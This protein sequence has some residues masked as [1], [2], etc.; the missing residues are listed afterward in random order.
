MR[1][2]DVALLTLACL[3]F[4]ACA[5]GGD[6]SADTLDPTFGD[7]GFDDEADEST[8]DPTQE[9]GT[10][11]GTEDT[12]DTEDTT[13]DAGGECGNGVVE[14]GEQCDG[15]DLGGATCESE[16]F[17]GGGLLCTADCTLDTSNC[18]LCGNGVVDEDEE[19]DGEDLGESSTC[20]DLNLG[21]AD[22]PLGCTADCTYD[23]GQCSGCGDG[24]VTPPEECE[25]PGD[26]LEKAELNGETCMSLG[27]DDG[28][29][30]CTEGCTFNTD[31]CYICGDA[32][33]QGQEECDGADFG[34]LSCGD[35][36][37]MSGDP[38][39]SG[40][41]SCGA[42]CSVDTSNCSL[43]GDGVITGAE[44]CDPGDLGGETCQSQGLDGGL[45]GCN[46][47]CSGFDLSACTDC[48]DG[49]IEG[50][51]QCDFN[52]LGGESCV[53]QGFPGGGDL[54]CTLEC[55]LDTSQCADNFCGDGIVNGSDEC[56]CGNQGVNCT[57][58]Q[59]GNQSCVGLGFDGGALACNSPNNC[60]YDT[61]GC[62]ECGDGNVD[63][64]EQCDGGN[65]DGES[66]T[67]QGFGGGGSL[68]CNSSC[69]FDT[70]GCVDVQNPFTQCVNTS[71]Q[72]SGAGPGAANPIIINVPDSGTVTDVDVSVDCLHTWPGDLVF[73]VSH[74]GQSAII[75]DQPG[76]PASTYGCSTDNIDAVFDDEG[77]QTA[78]DTCNITAP[79]LGSPPNLTPNNPLSIF[80]GANMSGN[81]NLIIDDTF[82]AGDDG[83][84][85]QFCVTVTWN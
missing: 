24:I 59:L 22:E 42:D 36:I 71:V 74:G 32:V 34:D 61:T 48:G 83:T 16:G 33:Q 53:S 27:F 76:A 37:A 70:S 21:S 14:A 57:A 17:G 58:A 50:D 41:L 18:T 9:T 19:C 30:D 4:A 3:N 73:T 6:P 10:D 80:D 72:I 81:W 47:D 25:P 8:T 82:S 78:E 66:C 39:D 55:V 56:D 29:L 79:G 45:L 1:R 12:S 46:A 43:C 51:E 15:G 44:V 38:Y 69:G 60:G 68:G 67:T 63:P 85:L 62:Y 28:L 23:F 2:I 65:L 40:S 7:D 49:V 35:Y 13:V 77:S 5:Q 84:L 31:S 11:A 64:G 20:A 54:Q 26:L 75:M 52:N